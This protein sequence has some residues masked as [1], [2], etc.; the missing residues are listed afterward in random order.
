MSRFMY[1][2]RLI[3]GLC[4][5]C[6][7][8]SMCIRCLYCTYIVSLI[9]FSFHWNSFFF[10]FLCFFYCTRCLFAATC[11]VTRWLN[12]YAGNANWIKYFIYQPFLCFITDSRLHAQKTINCIIFLL[13]S[14]SL[15]SCFAVH[16]ELAIFL[17]NADKLL[18]ECMIFIIDFQQCSSLFRL[19]VHWAP[20]AHW[21]V[22]E[23]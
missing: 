13:R 4:I 19:Y 3:R 22:N 5:E 18:F 8:T 16:D 20:C 6:E 15:L 14:F 17:S 23:S 21:A 7:R 11:A 1:F 12:V 10:S 2:S 9:L